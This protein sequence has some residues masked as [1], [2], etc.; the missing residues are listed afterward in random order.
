MKLKI[1]KP[2]SNSL[3]HLISIQKN[4]LSKNGRLI[5]Y[6]L[7]GIKRSF[8]RSGH[9]IT[10]HIG[11]GCKKLYR[12]LP[13]FNIKKY[14]INISSFYNPNT[15]S[16]CSINYDL[17]RNK[18]FN[19]ILI[20]NLC[21]GSLFVCDSALIDLNLG[22]RTMLKNIPTGSIVSNISPS[23]NKS[24]VFIKAAGTFGQ[25]IQKTKNIC[26]IK[27]PSSKIIEILNSCFCNIGI[28]S[29]KQSNKIVLAKAGRNRL[30]GKRPTVRGIAMNPVDHPHG[31]QTNGG[32]HFV[33][34]WGKP[35]KGRPTVKH[36]K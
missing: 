8:G 6:S 35:A 19:L 2:V 7:K 28:I 30:L 15:N 27:L 12:D 10:H 31:G 32:M 1:Y 36:K 21:A 4:L 24:N 33:T 18:F 29:N 26:K 3:R 5:K 22:Y 9:I 14:A 16:F 11:G 23:Y 25:I 20:N 17:L 13:S 34:P